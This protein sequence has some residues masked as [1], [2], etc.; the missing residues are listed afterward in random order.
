MGSLAAD[1]DALLHAA[2]VDGDALE[3]ANLVGRLSNPRI[4]PTEA[5]QLLGAFAKRASV[6]REDLHADLLTAALHVR[7]VEDAGVAEA[8]AVLA[9]ELIARSTA[10]VEP[11]IASIVDSFASSSQPLPDDVA[12]VA[13]ALLRSVLFTCPLGVRTLCELIHARF[14]HRR[15]QTAVHT[16]YLRHVLRVM[17]YEP[18]VQPILVPHI[19]QQ[20]LAIDAEANVP[21]ALPPPSQQP[22][23][24]D[25]EVDDDDQVFRMDDMH[26][27]WPPLPGGGGGGNGAPGLWPA[28]A[29]GQPPGGGGAAA[30]DPEVEKL[31]ALLALVFDFWS[32]M[33]G[34]GAGAGA[35]GGAG[36]GGVRA[37][38]VSA[39]GAGGA[40]GGKSHGNN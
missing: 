29:G 37:P 30:M 26:D 5:R 16:H 24:L 4:N 6:C 2:M 23:A 18:Y 36:M 7:W 21:A 14:P 27:G 13:H 22:S 25:D 11:F 19:I 28:V 10:F 17:S 15:L 35:G 20:L 32:R 39:A 34:G 33:F 31:D 12:D 1:S 40:G 3:Y 38:P 9:Q 8:Y